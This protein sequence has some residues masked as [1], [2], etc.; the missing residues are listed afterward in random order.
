MKAYGFLWSIMAFISKIGDVYAVCFLD[1]TR[2]STR[3]N[4]DSSQF[5]VRTGQFP[6]L[7]I[8]SRTSDRFLL[9]INA[10]TNK[11]C[12]VQKKSC[13]VGQYQL[14]NMIQGKMNRLKDLS[15]TTCTFISAV[16]TPFKM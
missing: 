3:S 4:D 16:V 5:V 10:A 15:K 13:S 1:L 7:L 14:N 2:R 11:R 8:V 6:K 12:N 9:S